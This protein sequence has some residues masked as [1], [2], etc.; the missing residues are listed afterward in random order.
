MPRTGGSFF[1]R[2][3]LLLLCDVSFCEAVADDAR[4][5]LADAG[6]APGVLTVLAEYFL[7]GVR[8]G[9]CKVKEHLLSV[10]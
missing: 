9:F 5:A 8:Q 10:A 2:L 6:V 7:P 3:L 4:N 1:N